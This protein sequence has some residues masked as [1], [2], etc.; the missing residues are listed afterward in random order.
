[1]I[2]L[3]TP[4]AVAFDFVSEKNRSDYYKEYNDFKIETFDYDGDCVL[5]NDELHNIDISCTEFTIY[6]FSLAVYVFIKGVDGR[7]E[8]CHKKS[9]NK[10]DLI[11]ISESEEIYFNESLNNDI[12]FDREDIISL[13]KIMELIRD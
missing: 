13:I 7:L 5:D 8:Q 6:I 9:Y 1:M 11:R 12:L 10:S 2:P 4:L 3:K